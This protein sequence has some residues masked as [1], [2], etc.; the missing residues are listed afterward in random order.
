MYTYCICSV[1][2]YIYVL[3]V[4]MST[5]GIGH[6]LYEVVNP[7]GIHCMKWEFCV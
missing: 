3:Q 5:S 7:Q 2:V 1:C 4:Q 6:T